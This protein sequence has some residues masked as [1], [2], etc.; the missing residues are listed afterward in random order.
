MRPWFGYCLTPMTKLKIKG[1]DDTKISLVGVI[2]NK[3]FSELLKANF[4]KSLAHEL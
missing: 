3:E 2:D 1:F 4:M